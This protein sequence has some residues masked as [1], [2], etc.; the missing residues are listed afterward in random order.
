[1]T[2]FKHVLVHNY[3]GILLMS[4][5]LSSAICL[6]SYCLGILCTM[7]S[8]DKFVTKY[9]YK[10]FVLLTRKRHFACVIIW[11]ISNKNLYR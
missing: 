9:F 4:G 11:N 10:Q 8:T 6:K 1:M 7:S 5:Y 3:I 2:F